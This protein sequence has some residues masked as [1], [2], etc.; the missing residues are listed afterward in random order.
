MNPQ[1]R[2]YE[3]SKAIVDR[4]KLTIMQLDILLTEIE[5]ADQEEHAEYS[6]DF[7]IED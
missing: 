2:K 7:E 5:I 3:I 6:Y 4:I 1:N